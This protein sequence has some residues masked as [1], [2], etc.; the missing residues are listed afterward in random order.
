MSHQSDQDLEVLRQATRKFVDEKVIPLLQK[1]EAADEMSQQLLDLIRDQ[2]YSGLRIAPNWGGK[3][4]SF[5]EYSAVLQEFGRA[6]P[7][8]L[9]WLGDSLGMSLQNFGSVQQKEKYLRPYSAWQLKGCLGFTEPEAGSDA[10][11][12]RTH[13]V[14]VPGGWLINGGKHY[15]SDQPTL[16]AQCCEL[17]AGWCRSLN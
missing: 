10:A 17:M 9:F 6:G 1:S 11:A 15:L 12:L 13:A 16:K 14:K 7:S 8:L 3:G 4:L 5:V 2:G